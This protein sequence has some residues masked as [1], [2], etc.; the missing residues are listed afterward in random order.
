MTPQSNKH[1]LTQHYT[2]I[3]FEWRK[4][5]QKQANSFIIPPFF[6]SPFL[7]QILYPID[8]INC[9]EFKNHPRL[10]FPH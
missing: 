5:D 8:H 2:L 3:L 4:L 10:S 9:I 7:L 1:K 6:Y